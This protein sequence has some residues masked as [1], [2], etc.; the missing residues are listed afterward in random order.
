MNI[1]ERNRLVIALSKIQIPPTPSRQEV[2]G[3]MLA[4]EIVCFLESF[5]WLSPEQVKEYR[6]AIFDELDKYYVPQSLN[7]YQL[8]VYNQLKDGEQSGFI[9]LNNTGSISF[10]GKNTEK[11]SFD[12]KMFWQALK[13]ETEKK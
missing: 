2:I 9:K 10:Y 12:A 4:D 6:K 1:E 7:E 8:K 5:G 3:T 13:E 11:C